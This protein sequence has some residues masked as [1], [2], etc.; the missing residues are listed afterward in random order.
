MILTT[1]VG[2]SSGSAFGLAG[3]LAALL[4]RDDLAQPV[5]NR[6][7]DDLGVPGRRPLLDQP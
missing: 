7:A 4:R 2:C 6:I 1:L 5:L 3:G